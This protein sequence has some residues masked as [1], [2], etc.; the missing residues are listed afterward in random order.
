MPDGR[1]WDLKLLPPSHS[2]GATSWDLELGIWNFA[3][4]RDLPTGRE[5]SVP[6]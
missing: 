4:R 5:V 6:G 3:C 1:F 2:F